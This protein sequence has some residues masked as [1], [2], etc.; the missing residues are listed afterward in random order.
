MRILTYKVSPSKVS[1]PTLAKY[2]TNMGVQR[3]RE[4]E[5]FLCERDTLECSR[6]YVGKIFACLLLEPW[7]DQFTHVNGP[8]CR[9]CFPSLGLSDYHKLCVHVHVNKTK[10]ETNSFLEHYHM[11]CNVKTKQT[12]G[13]KK[14]CILRFIWQGRCCIHVLFWRHCCLLYSQGRSSVYPSRFWIF[15]VKNFRYRVNEFYIY[16]GFY[17]DKWLFITYVLTYPTTW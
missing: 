11:T 7:T 5:P 9:F 2:K 3:E 6:V 12:R 17:I 1:L 4:R 15:T 13:N 8:P 10:F 14:R 16:I